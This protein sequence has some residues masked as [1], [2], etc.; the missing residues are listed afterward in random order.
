MK[1]NSIDKLDP[2]SGCWFVDK[3]RLSFETENG[4]IQHDGVWPM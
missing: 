3:N 2:L 4:I 1:L